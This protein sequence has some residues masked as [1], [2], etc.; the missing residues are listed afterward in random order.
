MRATIFPKT[1]GTSDG[2]E[3]RTTRRMPA[4]RSAARVALRL[5]GAMPLLIA[6]TGTAATPPA[7]YPRMAPVAAYLMDRAQEIALAR[8]AAPDSISGDATILVLTRTGYETA[9]TGTNGFVCMVARGFSGAP[10]WPERWNPKIRAAECENPQAARAIAPIARLRT[11]MTLAGRSDAE[12]LDRIRTAL[13]TGKIP[14]LG[15]GAMSYMM[16]KSA[17]LSD[18]GDHA[19]AHVMFFVPFKDGASWGANASASPVFGGNYWFATPAGGGA[20][21][22][23]PP[24]SVLLVGTCTWSD[25][26]PVAAHRM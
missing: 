4:L 13:R 22:A 25:G 24:V 9:V 3:P 8:S 2:G 6:I 10:D 12:I 21:A 23:L 14:P 5:I 15:P 20:A 7:S 16:S 18:D 19:M 1:A 11:A 17:Y 26:T